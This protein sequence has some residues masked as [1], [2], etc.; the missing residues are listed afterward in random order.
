MWIDQHLA[1]SPNRALIDEVSKTI[2]DSILDE[3]SALTAQKSKSLVIFDIDSTLIDTSHRTAAIFREFAR[4][5]THKESFPELC[6]EISN[7][8]EWVEVYDPIDFIN[9]HSGVK[10]RPESPE[11]KY[12]MK[13]WRERFFH[14]DWLVHDLPY[15]GGKEF[16]TECLV[17]GADV[18]Y[19]TARTV[20]KTL[21]GTKK[22][23][24]THHFPL[25]TNSLR[26]RLMLK[27]H[28]TVSD[29]N[30]KSSGLAKL[31]EGYVTSWFFENEV[32]LL[33]MALKNQPDITSILFDSVH[34]GRAQLEDVKPKVIT[35]WL[36]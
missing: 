5:P 29:L 9:V 20:E 7:W 4:E 23:L 25:K 30:Y 14:E 27:E 19:L 33:L 34:S 3:I 6:T 11:E 32:E 16:V 17:R 13:Y 10:I 21:T 36:R 15:S 24:A 35:S 1:E 2:L 22:W 28:Y 8:T 31:K 12:I 26:T 18:A